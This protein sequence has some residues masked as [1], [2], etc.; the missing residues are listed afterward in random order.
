[1]GVDS[2]L[3]VRKRLWRF[4]VGLGERDIVIVARRKDVEVFGDGV[5][6]QR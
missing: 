1:M 3:S 2:C 5:I 6:V 4:R